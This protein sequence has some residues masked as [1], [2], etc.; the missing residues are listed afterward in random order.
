MHFHTGGWL[1]ALLAGLSFLLFCFYYAKRKKPNSYFLYSRVSDLT[2][3][4]SPLIHLPSWLLLSALACFLIAWLDPRLPLKN[5][6]PLPPPLDPTEGRAFYLL[7]DQSG[8]MNQRPAGEI[9]SKMDILKQATARFIQDHPRDLIGLVAFARAAT[10][11]SPLTLDHKELLA[12]LN[13][14]T[15]VTSP[16]LDGTGIGYA[17]FKTASTL[18]AT[19]H[20]AEELSKEGKPSYQIER[21]SLILVTDG[22]QSP[23]ALDQGKKWRTLSMED[24]A[25]YASEQGIKVY[26]ITIEP[27]LAKEAFLP[28]RKLLTRVAEST[29]GQFFLL[30]SPE[31]LQSVYQAINQLEKIALPLQSLQPSSTPPEWPLSPFFILAGL[32]ALASALLLR[33]TYFR[34]AP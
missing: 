7:L 19:R 28:H 6:S 22:F 18:V 27:S 13:A 3:F 31:G 5:A 25:R 23:N 33:T 20:F 4:S 10:I 2:S 11:L 15:T 24:A 32:I 21:A 14:L 8:S 16:D 26:L 29:G 12:K 30:K 17:L 1:G 34:E 9:E